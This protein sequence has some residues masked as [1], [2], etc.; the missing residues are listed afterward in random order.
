M[1]RNTGKG[2]RIGSVDDRSQFQRPDGYW[3]KR[4]TTT[5]QFVDVKSDDTRFKGV[6]R[7]PDDR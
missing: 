2:Y 6:A 4:D 1:A 7:E 5:G 3:V